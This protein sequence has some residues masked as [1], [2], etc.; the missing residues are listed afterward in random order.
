MKAVALRQF[1]ARLAAGQPVL[2][3]WVTL[4]SASITEM[5]VALGLDWVVI[6]AEH[7]HLDYRE[8]LEHVRAAVRSETVVLV[9]VVDLD[10]GVVKRVLD[11]GA[12]GILVPWMETADQLRQALAFARYP[13]EGVR[14]IGG[15]RATCWGQCLPAHVRE[16]NENVLVVPIV[17]SV[18]AMRNLSSLLAVPGVDVFFF[19]PSDYSSSAGFAGQWEGPGVAEQILAA[20][21][22]IRGAGRQVG[23]IATGVEDLQ[24]RIEQG[25]R[26][27]A[28]GLDGG[29][30]IRGLRGALASLGRDRRMVPSLEAGPRADAPPRTG[31]TSGEPRAAA[32]EVVAGSNASSSSGGSAGGGAAADAVDLAPGVSFVC[33]L[34]PSNGAANLTAGV[35]TFARGAVLPYHRHGFTE[36]ITLLSGRA[37]VEVEGR[38]YTLAPLDTITIPA[39]LA[40]SASNR[41]A[42]EPAVLHTAM[43]SG[44]PARIPVDQ[45]FSRRGMSAD[46]T[47]APNAERVTRYRASGR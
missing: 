8:I 21:E 47:G 14:G 12:D 28:L 7:G 15:E 27:V 5:A 45:F 23:V 46:C 26:M 38:M 16:A 2:G 29:L 39:G 31:T 34:G 42:T 41:S 18:Q 37:L 30:L 32:T 43:A 36:S 1:R 19:G 3:L 35:V 17:E 22:Q 10:K 24:R 13:L 44:E 6:D 40:H 4:E 9:R 11:I 33:H 20:K 25:F